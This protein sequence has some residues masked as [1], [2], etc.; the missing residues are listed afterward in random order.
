MCVPPED[1]VR[2]F[3]T[4]GTTGIP[5]RVM[6][7]KKDWTVHF[8][9]QFMHFMHAYGIK[10]LRHPLC[11]HSDTGSTLPG[12]DFRRPWNRPEC[13]DCAGGGAIL[14]RP[15]PKYL[16]LGGQPWSAAPPPISFTWVK[17]REKMGISLADSSGVG[18]RCGRRTGRQCEI[19]EIGHRDIPGGLNAMMISAPAKSPTSGFECIFQQGTHVNE[20]M[21]YAECLNPDTLEPVK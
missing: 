4:T 6:L 10:T 13:H 3:Q 5:V 2:V 18:G 17:S 9:E 8:Y 15:G 21:F 14:Q 20:N 7:N 12:G 19:H 1:G 11:A 16:R